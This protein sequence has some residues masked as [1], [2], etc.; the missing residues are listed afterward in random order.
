MRLLRV[1]DVRRH[2]DRLGDTGGG[3]PEAL[4]ASCRDVIDIEVSLDLDLVRLQCRETRLDIGDAAKYE[5][6]E[7]GLR[8]P[9]V[10][11]ALERDR[12]PLLP[13]RELERSGPD[14]L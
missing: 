6:V 10:R 3:H 7:P 13:F 12:L 1:H 4:L 2:E 8:A 14:R 11:V 9:V 5:P